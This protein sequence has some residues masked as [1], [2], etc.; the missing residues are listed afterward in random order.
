MQEYIITNQEKGQRL[1]KYV[2]RILREA[3]SSFIYKMLRKKNITLNGHKA[4]GK[5]NVT[6][7]D[8]V[9][10]FLS[11]ETFQKM[12]GVRKEGMRK[13]AFVRPEELRFSEA[14]KAYTEL[15][16]R[17]PALGLVY[18]DENIAAAYKPAGV[19]SQKAAPSDLSL[20]E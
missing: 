9:K 16:R 7:G 15:T 6:Q 4:E 10:L 5:E 18:E 11:D 20:N 8:S 14:D 19:L 1:D 13:D 17:Y 2:K 12:G 3:P